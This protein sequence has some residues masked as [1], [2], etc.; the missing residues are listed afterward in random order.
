AYHVLGTSA[1][2]PSDYTT[3]DYAR[4]LVLLLGS[5]REGLSTEQAAVC[6][7]VVRLPM[8]GRASSLNLSV[9]TGVMLYAMLEK[10]GRG[11]GG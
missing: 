6:Q 2:S 5:E 3:A 9:A 7:Q 8:L 11:I 4:P 1:R 10:M